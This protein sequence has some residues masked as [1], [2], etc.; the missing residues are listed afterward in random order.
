VIKVAVIFIYT[1]RFTCTVSSVCINALGPAIPK[2]SPETAMQPSAHMS[3]LS[4]DGKDQ[5]VEM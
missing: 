1:L 5:V 4:A 3:W 2:T